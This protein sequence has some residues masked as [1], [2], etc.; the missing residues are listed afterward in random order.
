MF[1]FYRRI[2]ASVLLLLFV[3][4]PGYGQDLIENG[5]TVAG[6]QYEIDINNYKSLNSFFAGVEDI[7]DEVLDSC[8]PDLVIFPEYTG[9]FVQLIPYFSKVKSYD[10]FASALG[11]LVQADNDIDNLTDVFQNT[12]EIL[13]SALLR[14][15]EL[16]S[17]YSVYIL[18]GSFFVSDDEDGTVR[19]RTYVFNPEGGLEYTQD[20]VFLTEFETDIVGLEPGKISEAELFRVSGYSIGVSIC[21]D[22]YFPDWEER[23]QDAF[24][25]IDIKANG[26]I[27]DREQQ[28][29]F[30]RALP[31]R[32]AESEVAYGMT[33]CTVG[34][35]L[36]LLW[37]G[38]SSVIESENGQ[39]RYDSKAETADSYDLI[40]FSTDY[41]Q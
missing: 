30:M 13:D 35:Y 19:N 31:A 4:L 6:V 39:V 29:S 14:W 22:T 18:A 5:L 38:R 37:E 34:S 8:E 17:E 40:I 15:A 32:I 9:V 2:A 23:F 21:R 20:K 12:E 24:L 25:W 10:S 1:C 41:L 7:L 27:F 26:E 11:S 36:D 16:S 33:V 3:L 28:R